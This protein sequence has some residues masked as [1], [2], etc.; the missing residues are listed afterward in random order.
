MFAVALA[1]PTTL[2]GTSARAVGTTSAGVD[3]TLV[4]TV[5]PASAEQIGPLELPEDRVPRRP[6]PPSARVAVL[7]LAAAPRPI[8]SLEPLVLDGVVIASWYGPGFFGNRTACGITYAPE[9]VGVAHRTLP[10]G[11]RIRLTSPAG[12]TLVVPVID[13]GPYVAGRALDLSYA[14]KIALHCSDLCS[15]RMTVVQ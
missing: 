3:G 8:P 5:V 9:I 7:G 12:V 13:R 11:T 10:C 2:P 6:T 1:L 4:V 14:T 15:V